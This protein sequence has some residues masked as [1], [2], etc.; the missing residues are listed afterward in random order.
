MS[1]GEFTPS[2]TK[3]LVKDDNGEPASG[4]FRYSSVLGVLLFLS[5]NTRTYVALSVNSSARYMFS[6]K[7]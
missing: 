2:E 3:L 1:K 4:V 7:Y 5:G 6:H